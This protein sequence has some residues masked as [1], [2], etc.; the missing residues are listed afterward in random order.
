MRKGTAS[1]TAMWVAAM[2]G[3]AELDDPALVHDALAADLLPLRYAS[4]LRVARRVPGASRTVLRALAIASGNL[5]RHLAFRTRAID[6]VVSAEA[7]S[8]TEQLVL[9]GA[10]FDA[11]AWRLSALEGVT[12]FEVDHPDTQASKRAGI[13]ERRALARELRWVPVD[14]AEESLGSQASLTLLDDALER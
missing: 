11:R 4:V 3:L 12:V 8:G 5:S 6:D 14:F 2:R 9:L 13:G 7:R 1:R 10:G